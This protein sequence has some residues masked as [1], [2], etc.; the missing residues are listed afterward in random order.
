MLELVV[1]ALF[2]AFIVVAGIGHV[3]LFKAVMKPDR[4][5]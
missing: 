1:C 3:M 2:A 4:Q 5:S